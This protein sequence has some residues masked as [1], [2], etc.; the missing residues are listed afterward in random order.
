[1]AKIQLEVDDI[2]GQLDEE[3]QHKLLD[4]ML[5][6]VPQEDLAT[7]VRNQFTD[8]KSLLE[9]IGELATAEESEDEPESGSKQRGTRGK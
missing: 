2:L 8:E 4:K 6:D 9:F 1:M 3:E 7:I 5:E